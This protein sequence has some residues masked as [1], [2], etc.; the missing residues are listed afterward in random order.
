MTAHEAEYRQ[1]VETARKAGEPIAQHD[2]LELSKA[3]EAK[4]E[5]ES[6]A[7]VEAH[8]EAHTDREAVAV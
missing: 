3:L 8:T 5:A 7:I 6:Q 2:R 4:A 1:Q